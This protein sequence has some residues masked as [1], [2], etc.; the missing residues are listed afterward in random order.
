MKID[1]EG[2]E[3]NVIESWS[4][5][6]HRPWVLV[7]ESTMPFSRIK[8]HAEWEGALIARDYE[9]VY[10]DGLNKYYTNKKNR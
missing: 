7:I 8:V 3:K 9:F 10:F 1:V 5:S 6:K 2:M 4:E